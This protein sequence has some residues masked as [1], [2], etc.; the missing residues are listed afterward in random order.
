MGYSI[1][2]LA[3]ILAALLCTVPF[4]ILAVRPSARLANFLFERRQVIPN[5]LSGLLTISL[6][7]GSWLLLFQTKTIL[8]L[9]IYHYIRMAPFFAWAALLTLQA[10][11]LWVWRWRK[12]H[13]SK[14]AYALDTV[15]ILAIWLLSLVSRVLLTGF[16]LPYQSIWDEPVTYP[17]ALNML[18]TPGLRPYADVPGYGNTSYGD[19]P[20][21]LTA[22]AE[23]LGLMDGFNSQQVDNVQAYVSPPHGVA[24]IY[25]A[26]NESGLP[27]RIPRL[28]F[29]LLNSLLAPLVYLILRRFFGVDPWSACGAALLLAF[30]SRDVL[31]YSSYILPDALATTIFTCL[32]I[33]VWLAMDRGTK[34]WQPWLISGVLGG[35]IV[36]TNIRLLV[37]VS[38]PFL[39]LLLARRTSDKAGMESKGARE[40]DLPGNGILPAGGNL[41]VS[42]IISAAAILAGLVLGFVLTSPYA[43][44]DLP[45]FIAKWTSFSWYHILDWQHRLESIAFYLSGMFKTGF[46]VVYIDTDAGSIGLGL[47]AGILAALGLTGLLKRQP[48]RTLL[49]LIFAVLQLYMISPVVQRFTRHA[50]VLYPIVAIA[51]GMGLFMIAQAAQ[52]AW[53]RW[54]PRL[55]AKRK[56]IQKWIPVLVLALFVLIYAG[57]IGEVVRYIQRIVAYQP[58][59][60]HAAD[61]LETLLK[62]GDKVGILDIV[63]WVESDLNR[64]GINYVRVGLNDKLEQWQA[65]GLTYVVGTDREQ[66]DFGSAE[67]TEWAQTAGLTRIAEFGSRYLSFAGYPT[68]ELYLYVAP[69]PGK[70]AGTISVSGEIP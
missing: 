45:N 51:A 29:A 25:Q 3:M 28:A 52:K 68:N 27:L 14:P 2:R 22:A 50:L 57:Q 32:L 41:Y 66:F 43:L 67:G 39:A 16:G 19:L 58:I 56:T 1:A 55:A 40:N 36:S 24:S 37:V 61:Y 62:P 47:P 35:I 8:S 20:V 7:I 23:V 30:L 42:M 34:R 38:L 31:Y 60:V 44:L 33:S 54:A 17:Q 26:V 18:T 12:P 15:L 11:A 5:L 10:G 4:V 59:Q 6:L 53:L 48:R 21:Y 13:F 46:G 49:M 65:E 70:A 64:R 9:T 63:P 69:V